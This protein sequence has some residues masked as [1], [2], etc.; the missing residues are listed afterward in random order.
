[1]IVSYEVQGLW[2]IPSDGSPHKMQLNSFAPEPKLEYVT[3]PKHT[4]AVYRRATISNSSDSPLL[5]GAAML[6]VN[7]NF[8]GNTQLEYTPQSAEIELLLGVEEQIKVERE[9]TKREVDKRFL[10]ENRVI[11]YGYEI[12]L[13]N[14][15]QEVAMIEV[16]DQIPVSRHEQIKVKL[17]QISPEPREKTDLNLLEWNVELKPNEKKTVAYE[18]VVEHPRSMAIG[19]LID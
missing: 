6:F 11:R 2:D 4:G 15:M 1:M 19:G 5:A 14:L 7:E 18:F 12:R 8:I 10:R 16:H 17:E 13:E 3:V 9:L